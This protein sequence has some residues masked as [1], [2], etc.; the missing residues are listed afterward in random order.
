[1]AIC[2]LMVLDFMYKTG[3]FPKCF[4]HKQAYSDSDLIEGIAF[5]EWLLKDGIDQWPLY[6]FDPREFIKWAKKKIKRK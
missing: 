5:G 6:E 4:N 1:M 2:K 3:R